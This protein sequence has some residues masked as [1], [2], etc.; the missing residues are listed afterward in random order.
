MNLEWED[1]PYATYYRNSRFPENFVDPEEK[2]IIP[3]TD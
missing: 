3:A 1:P 2:G